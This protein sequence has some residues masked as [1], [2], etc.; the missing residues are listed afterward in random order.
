MRNGILQGK[1][2]LQ[3]VTKGG[4]VTINNGQLTINNA[5]EATIYLTAGTTYKNYKDVSADAASPCIK[6]LVSNKICTRW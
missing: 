6:A 3:I 5:D 1:S 4:A 2:Y